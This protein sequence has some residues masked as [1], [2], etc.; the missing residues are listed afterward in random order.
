MHKKNRPLFI[1]IEGMDGSGK[2]TISAKLASLLKADC[3]STPPN[4]SF[5]LELRKLVEDTRDAYMDY[6]FFMIGNYYA[7]LDIKMRLKE[8]R[9]VVCDRYYYSTLAFHKFLGRVEVVPEDINDNEII[10]PDYL[11]FLTAS[12]EE[13]RNRISKRGQV[14]YKDKMFFDP[15]LAE[16]IKGFY[17]KWS[18]IIIDTTDATEDVVIGKI[19]CF[20]PKKYLRK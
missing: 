16:K 9:S 20:L 14:S 7:S 18:P 3:Y 11:F 12:E 6:L 17:E 4:V 8:G 10:K 15:S 5:F 1:V 2:S 19:I 13:R